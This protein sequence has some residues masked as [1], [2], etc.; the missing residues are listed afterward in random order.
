MRKLRPRN[1]TRT[2]P[3]G[4]LLST[5]EGATDKGLGARG[6]RPETRDQRPRTEN[7]EGRQETEGEEEEDKEKG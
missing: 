6:R 1:T 5:D 3:R 7:D 2:A 4:M